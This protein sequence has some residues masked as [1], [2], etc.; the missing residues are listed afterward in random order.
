ML[1][2]RA[3]AACICLIIK[4]VGAFFIPKA[5]VYMATAAW[6]RT[7]PLSHKSG[8]NAMPV[9]NF[10]NACFKQYSTVCG[11]QHIGVFNS[12]LI[13]AIAGFGMQPFKRHTKLVQQVEDIVIKALHFAWPQY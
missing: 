6:Q 4:Q 2:Q 8:D 12:G 3:H 1:K 9:S 13:Y 7:V 11:I 5:L 10:F